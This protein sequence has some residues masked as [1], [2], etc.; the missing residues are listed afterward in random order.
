MVR[1]RLFALCGA[2]CLACGTAH[3]QPAGDARTSMTPRAGPGYTNGWSLMTPQERH[4]YQVKIMAMPSVYA[5]RAFVED[6][7]RKMVA[8]AKETNAGLPP[9]PRLDV[10]DGLPQ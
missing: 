1:L 10:C 4:D 6:H 3:A 5:C 2:T 8:R 9:P 7:H